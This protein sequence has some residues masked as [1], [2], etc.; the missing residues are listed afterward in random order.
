MEADY[1]ASPTLERVHRSVFACLALLA[2][3]LLAAVPAG[4][5]PK[6]KAKPDPVLRTL[7]SLERQ[8]RLTPEDRVAKAELYQAVRSAGRRA[9]GSERQAL[10]GVADTAT[11]L[12]KRNM[13]G[14]RIVPIWLNLQR[15][16]EWFVT[17]DRT[18]PASGAR[19][20]FPPSR[21]EYQFVPSA[22]WQIHPLANF[23]RLNALARRKSVSVA[24]L[25]G[26]A[27]ELATIAVSRRGS[28]AWEYHFPWYEAKPGWVSGMASATGLSALARVGARTADPKYGQLADQSLSLFEQDAPW[29]VRAPDRPG[30]YVLY[31]GTPRLL[32]GNGFA[33][34]VIGLHEYATLT[35]SPRARALFEA[36]ERELV[37]ELPGYDTGAWSLYSLGGAESSLHYHR[38]F[39]DF[40]AD[41][42][43]RLGA[44]GTAYCDT[45]KR[46]R[47][48]ELQPIAL[49]AISLARRGKREWTLSVPVSKLGRL[50]VELTEIDAEGAA[51]RTVATRT[52]SISRGTVRTVIPRPRKAASYRVSVEATSLTGVTSAADRVV[53]VAKPKRR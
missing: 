16:Y 2:A 41:L 4:A 53:V 23:G 9:F 45:E 18:T 48:Y 49:G 5:A 42:C 13:L 33:Q 22:G 39:A 43:K 7:Q 50:A 47:D 11:S 27:D 10:L 35:G 3:L 31:S 26:Y 15:T 1:P 32:V 17:D 30:H 36:G 8:G 29:G 51:R 52:L 12:A 19:V 20:T 21:L 34:A 6:K 46:F 24:R 14:A 40:L 37:Q 44:V 25:R 28:L 38:V